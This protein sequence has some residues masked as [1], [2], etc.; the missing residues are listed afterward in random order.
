[1][2]N[3]QLPTAI[4]QIITNTVT[5]L[6]KGVDPVISRDD[7]DEIQQHPE[8]SIDILSHLVASPQKQLDKE[9]YALSS[10]IESCLR[11]L[12]IC[13]ANTRF[14]LEREERW[15]IRLQEQ[16]QRFLKAALKDHGECEYW[17]DIFSIFHEAGLSL[18]EDV[19]GA[20]LELMAEHVDEQED[21]KQDQ[22]S[23]K[24]LLVTILD[25]N[26]S[27]SVYEL[28]DIFFSN[29]QAMPAEF[30]THFMHELH[31]TELEIASDLSIL[32][33]LHTDYAVRQSVLQGLHEVYQSKCVTPLS[34]SRLLR[35]RDWWPDDDK[36]SLEHF[37]KQQRKKGGAFTS[38]EAAEVVSIYATEFDG[39]GV[40]AFFI[41]F[42]RNQL[43]AVGGGLVKYQ[44]GLRD[45][46]RSPWMTKSEARDFIRKGIGMEATLRKVNQEYLSTIVSHYI[47]V[48]C[49][50]GDVPHPF[51][52]ELNELLQQNWRS[53]PINID[54][55]LQDL[56][57]DI[58]QHFDQAYIQSSLAKSGQWLGKKNF[59]DSWFEQSEVI[60]KIVNQN[61]RLEEGVRYCEVT[62]A[63][64]A[65]LSEVFEPLR[66]KWLLQFI[67]MA[68]WARSRAKKNERMWKDLTVLAYCI[69]QGKPLQDLPIIEKLA[70]ETVLISLETMHAR[71]TH[72]NAT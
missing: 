6:E 43:Y 53:E 72:L 13:L 7:Y 10:D 44:I 61:T 52:L 31:D 9:S 39:T 62:D 55:K 42:R 54:Q 25:K 36:V 12:D 16:L 33:L 45:V 65:I 34:L 48:G 58:D 35:I 29:T 41:E 1:M 71:G 37:I 3:K 20:Y 56:I 40:Q 21:G 38:V 51:C 68:M 4:A 47:S 46:W 50:R 18:D 63:V 11:V 26:P 57:K 19:K 32:F 49:A 30:F 17:V 8:F 69:D 14:A 70:N 67:F 15:A 64:G 66:E 28:C 24:R 22:M 23:L 59:V 2:P 27:V 5:N 60:D